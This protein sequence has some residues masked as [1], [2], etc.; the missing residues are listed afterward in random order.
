MTEPE[1]IENFDPWVE[2]GGQHGFI[3]KPVA[4]YNIVFDDEPQLKRFYA[5]IKDLKKIYPSIRTHGGRI[6]QFLADREVGIALLTPP[7][8]R[9]LLVRGRSVGSRKLTARQNLHHNLYEHR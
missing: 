7:P 8:R 5:F 2:G 6:D 9:N 1:P 3:G 4:S